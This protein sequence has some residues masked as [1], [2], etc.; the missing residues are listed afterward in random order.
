VLKKRSLN[1]HEVKDVPADDPEGTLDRFTDG[2]KRVLS[3]P[4][5]RLPKTKL[6]FGARLRAARRRGR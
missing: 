1:S 4:K 2:L 5:S 6:S 3:V